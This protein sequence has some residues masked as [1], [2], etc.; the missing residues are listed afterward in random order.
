[1]LIN[2]TLENVEIRYNGKSRILAP[3][4]AIDIRD[5]DVENKYVVP[6]EK[7]IMN[8]YPGI[9][10]QK[11]TIGDPKVEGKYT[12]QI[13]TL[14][15]RIEALTKE[16][17]EVRASEKIAQEKHSSSAGEVEAMKQ[18]VASMKKEVDKY[19]FET[20]ELEQEN[21]KLREQVLKVKGKI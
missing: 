16:L 9:Y 14:E 21:Q 10:D 4:E 13:K 2:K 3:S 8:K 7:H 5:F 1:M 11:P 6:A 15:G 12:E 17:A 18:N 19:Q 20:K